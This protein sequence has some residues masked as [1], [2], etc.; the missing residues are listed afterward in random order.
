M[1]ETKTHPTPIPGIPKIRPP[2]K[3]EDS[4]AVY[5]IPMVKNG[6]PTYSDYKY[7][8][9]QIVSQSAPASIAETDGYLV[10]PAADVKLTSILTKARKALLELHDFYSV[11]LYK[12]KGKWDAIER[13]L[14]SVQE[15]E[16]V[17]FLSHF[18]KSVEELLNGVADIYKQLMPVEHA[19]KRRGTSLP[20]AL[21]TKARKTK[22]PKE[23]KEPK[24]KKPRKNPN[25]KRVIS[26]V[27]FNPTPPNSPKTPESPRSDEATGSGDS[28]SP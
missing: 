8:E 6:T 16:E 18:V 7:I 12:T 10:P 17:A 19:K 4:D 21:P 27:P 22:E 25:P 14:K 26:S 13:E 23:P 11:E 15:S 2:E 20:R 5:V 1:A 28:C 3:K 24:A 9:G